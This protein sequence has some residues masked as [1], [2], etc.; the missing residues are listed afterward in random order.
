MHLKNIKYKYNTSIVLLLINK[1]QCPFYI[2]ISNGMV[3]IYNERKQEG[4]YNDQTKK[5]QRQAMIYKTLHR[6]L[7]IK[8]YEPHKTPEVN[9]NS[10]YFTSNDRRVSF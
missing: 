7:K 4:Q 8:H 6:K 1:K 9:V 10:L 2:E 3:S 5:D